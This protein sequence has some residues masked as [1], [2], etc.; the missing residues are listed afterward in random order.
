MDNSG[1]R[2]HRN[3]INIYGESDVW[4]V[5]ITCRVCADLPTRKNVF[6]ASK[7]IL[8]VL[9]SPSVDVSSEAKT[10]VAWGHIP[11]EAEPSEASPHWSAHTVSTW[12]KKACLV[13]WL[14]H[15]VNLLF[16]WPPSLALQCWPERES[17]RR[18]WGA[19]WRKDVCQ[20]SFAGPEL[21]CCRLSSALMNP[22]CTPD[23]G[24]LASDVPPTRFCVDGSAEMFWL[25]AP[26]N[27]LALSPGAAGQ[28]LQ[29]LR[30]TELPCKTRAAC[31]LPLSS[32]VSE[33]LLAIFSTGVT[34]QLGTSQVPA[35]LRNEAR[36]SVS[37]SSQRS[38]GSGGGATIRATHTCRVMVNA[39]K[40]L[41]QAR[42]LW[43]A[44]MRAE[45][46]RKQRK[47]APEE[48][49]LSMKPWQESVC[50]TATWPVTWVA[51][52]QGERRPRQEGP[53]GGARSCGALE[54]DASQTW[55]GP[56]TPGVWGGVLTRSQL[57]PLPP[58]RGPYVA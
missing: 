29:Q 49:G 9:Q 54:G 2:A 51:S 1:S 10:G 18:R 33:S 17:A 27:G 45:T 40:N 56:L 24:S 53:S 30:S 19:L 7:L 55:R 52:E 34:Q 15:F 26:R 57:M 42:L 46:Y 23:K 13:L 37:P 48:G 6:V 28:H 22:Q 12:P 14:L 31:H 5:L 58:A 35:V 21:W 50:G 8:V 4:L 3:T 11:A 32:E 16:N 41:S 36:P 43:Q 38:G 47:W 20:V 25:G 44:E 39:A